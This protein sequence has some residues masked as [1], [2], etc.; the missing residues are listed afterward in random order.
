MYGISPSL[1]L[2][3]K[4]NEGIQLTKTIE[5]NTK[6]NLKNL[7]LT[8]P[9]ERIMD[10]DFGVGLR[11][12]LF[13]Q[14]SSTVLARLE[15]AISDQV[16]RYMPFVNI[17]NLEVAMTEPQNENLLQVRIVYEI[18]GISTDEILDVSIDPKLNT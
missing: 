12:Y 8:A 2:S 14:G 11:N 17:T 15:G 6:Q 9:G 5:E 18:A 16:E 7:I 1:P 13:D 10:P 3:I 4:K